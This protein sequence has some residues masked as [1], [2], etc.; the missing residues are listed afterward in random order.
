MSISAS[1]RQQLLQHYC[2]TTVVISSLQYCV[3]SYYYRLRCTPIY[4]TTIIET[5]YDVPRFTV[6]LIEA[7]AFTVL[8]IVSTTQMTAA[9]EC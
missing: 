3:I 8:Y 9:Q 2:R 5:S 7:G 6:R 4:C 1:N